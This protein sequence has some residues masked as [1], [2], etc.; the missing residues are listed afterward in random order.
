MGEYI[1]VQAFVPVKKNDPTRLYLE[2]HEFNLH[3][4]R[5]IE[6]A[7]P[8]TEV[9]DYVGP[10]PRR[11]RIFWETGFGEKGVKHYGTL[12]KQVPPH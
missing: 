3:A 5:I 12:R 8:M 4:G 9:M 11:R 7:H 6:F 2:E 10:N 1:Q